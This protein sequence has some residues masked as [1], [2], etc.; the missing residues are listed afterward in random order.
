MIILKKAVLKCVSAAAALSI[1]ICGLS[2]CGKG[3]SDVTD[4]QGRTKLSIGSWPGEGDPAR[5]GMADRKARFEKANPDFAIVPDD[6][7][8]DLKSF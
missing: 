5:E 6:W 8:F 1:A 7:T 4:S 2:G 3:N